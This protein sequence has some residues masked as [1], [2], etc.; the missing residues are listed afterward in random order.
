MRRANSRQNYPGIMPGAEIL[1][2]VKGATY[3][4]R[5]LKILDSIEQQDIDLCDV[6]PDYYRYLGQCIMTRNIPHLYGMAQH[7]AYQKTDFLTWG[8][9]R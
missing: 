4:K 7:R 8:S 1:L 5:A 6:S 9:G 2:W 3:V